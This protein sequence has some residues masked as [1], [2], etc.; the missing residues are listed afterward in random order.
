MSNVSDEAR[1]VEGD[2]VSVP[3]L[4]RVLRSPGKTPVV[5]RQLTSSSPARRTWQVMKRRGGL[6]V[7]G[8]PD[9]T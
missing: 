4:Q 9:S 5:A 3:C 1:E 2:L 6:E 8:D 7:G